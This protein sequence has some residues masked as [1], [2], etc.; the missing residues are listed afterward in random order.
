MGKILK[1]ESIATFYSLHHQKGKS[2]TF[3]HFKK[4][5][6]KATIYRIMKTFDEV[7]F[8]PII[9]ISDNLKQKIHN[10]DKNGLRSLTKK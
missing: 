6:H 1:R 4:T 10:A 3:K 8:S 7:D 5:A 2:C 9:K